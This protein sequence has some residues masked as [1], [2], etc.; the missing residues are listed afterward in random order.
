MGGNISSKPNL[1]EKD[2]EMLH[3]ISKK[4]KEEIVFWYEHFIKECPSGKLDRERFID[5]Y[6]LFKKNEKNVE[7]LAELCFLAF[8]S[9]NNGYVDF[10]EFYF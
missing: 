2:L 3:A 9:D 7:D 4:P 8:D 1:T 5:F 6:K 10:N